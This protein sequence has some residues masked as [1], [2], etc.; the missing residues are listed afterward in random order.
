MKIIQTCTAMF[1]GNNTRYSYLVPDGDVPER[2]DL[3]LTSVSF[4][5]CFDL[6][7]SDETLSGILDRAKLARIVCLDVEPSAR[8]T[9]F[10]LQLITKKS[11]IDKQKV[12]QDMVKRQRERKSARAELDKMLRDNSAIELYRRLA[13]TNPEAQRLLKILED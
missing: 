1:P 3:I 5:P 12:N 8:A 7:C 2:G 13:E 4:D 10:Y 11:I 6:N 9:K